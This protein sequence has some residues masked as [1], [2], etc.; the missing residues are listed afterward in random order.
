MKNKQYFL[1]TIIVI[2]TL[3]LSSSIF[4]QTNNKFVKLINSPIVKIIEK[5]RPTIVHLRIK[6]QV[7]FAS[8][9]NR[10]GRGKSPFDDFF[11]QPKNKKRQPETQETE[12]VGSGVI[13]SKK[14]YILTNNHVIDNAGKITV[15]L[16]N[17][18]EYPAQIIGGDFYSDIA[19]IQFKAPKKSFKVA[20]LGDSDK[21]KV[22]ETAL[23]LGSPF[24]LR[25]SV[26][27]GIISA[28][29]RKNSVGVNFIQTD[30]AINPGNSGGALINLKG[31]VIGI[32]T[33]ILTQPDLSSRSAGFQG[34]GLAI[35]INLAKKIMAQIIS[36][37]RVIRGFLGI[38]PANFNDESSKILKIP[39]GVMVSLVIPKSPAKK[40]GLQ[41]WDLIIKMDKQV[42]KNFQE[43]RDYITNSKVGSRIQLTIIRNK[44]QTIINV[45][46]GDLDTFTGNLNKTR[47][48]PGKKPA[49]N[50]NDPHIGLKVQ[51]L[52]PKQKQFLSKRYFVDYGI[53]ILEVKANSIAS[54]A[55]LQKG[56]VILE[57]EGIAI[58]T[59][60]S[61]FATIKKFRRQQ[62]LKIRIIKRGR[63]LIIPLEFK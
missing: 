47:K 27:K 33:A 38:E 10:N 13:V 5:V 22:G 45:V 60:A 46:L 30:A 20:R 21:L 54:K 57:A 41:P 16:D 6:R 59:P 55:K 49:I 19:V 53:I 39:Q 29:G 36:H 25:Q 31:E 51:K 7:S 61:F 11:N 8:F 37:G 4:S 42:V 1:I 56:D 9:F 26:T 2:S 63:V 23:A 62:F 28:K 40:A 17:N 12:M 44:K 24:G 32:N 35:P 18:E 15:I 3:T 34:V 43:L 14:G 52:K 58:K 48:R 50:K